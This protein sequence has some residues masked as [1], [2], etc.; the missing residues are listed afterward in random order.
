MYMKY[1]FI[2]TSIVLAFFIFSGCHNNEDRKQLDVPQSNLVKIDGMIRTDSTAKRI[3][4]A[5]WL[6][7]YGE[8]IYKE[9]PFKISLKDSIWVVEGTSQYDQGGTAYIE[10]QAKDGKILKMYHSK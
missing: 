3:A 8:K 2:N 5:V 9:Y 7:F 10:I 4:E 6:Q 1:M